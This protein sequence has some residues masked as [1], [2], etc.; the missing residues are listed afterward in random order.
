M[1]PKVG[2]NKVKIESEDGGPGGETQ[3]NNDQ[4]KKRQR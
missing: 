3:R 1:L 2:G 4:V